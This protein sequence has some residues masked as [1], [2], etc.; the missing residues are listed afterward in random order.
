[1]SENIKKGHNHS[2]GH[3]DESGCEHGC[4]CCH[5][6][7]E[8]SERAEKIE[9]LSLITGATL[10]ALSFL[11]FFTDSTGNILAI[12]SIL[13]AVFPVLRECAQE[14]KNRTI[15][16]NML[17]AIAVFSACVLGDFAEAAAVTVLFRAG[18]ALEEYA[19]NRSKRSITELSQIRPDTA[20]I[21]G[22]D[23]K[24]VEAPAESIKIGDIITVM[25]YER[26]PLDGV[27]TEG[28]SS[29]DASAI[30]GES[31]PVEK[32]EGDGVMS[33]MIN[34]ANILKVEVTSEFSQS[35]ASRIIEMVENASKS[36]GQSERMITRFA[37][38]Y[39][40]AVVTCA[41]LLAVVPIL[42]FNGD[43]SEYI[44]RALVFLVA[45]CPCA[46]V[47]SV[48]LSFF[49]GI[50]AASKKGILVKGGA[51]V[52]T[53]EKIRAVVFDKT[54]TLT[55][56]EF[57]V[58]NVNPCEGVSANELLRIAAAAEFYSSHPIA[59]AIVKAYGEVDEG[60]IKNFKELRAR[61]A[62][63]T[64][65][66]REIL[67]G[68][69]RLMTENGI[70]TNGVQKAEI[71]VAADKKCIGS[72]NVEGK[73][74]D[75]SI[76]AIEDL[77]RLGI[78]HIVI[79]TGDNEA[80][81]KKA[82]RECSIEEYHHSLL[83]EDKIDRLAEIRE[84]YG[85]TAFVGDGINDAP[86]L[87]LADVGVAMGLGTDAAIEAGDVVLMNSAPSKLAAAIRL[88]K[89]TMT[90]T[91]VNIA[92]AVI[93]KIAVLILGAAGIATMW[94]AVFADVGVTILAVLNSSRLLMTKKEQ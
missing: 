92:F 45:S 7:E 6:G 88:F 40:P 16:E 64:L 25:P 66:G 61:G 90:V 11:P 13:A 85:A 10:F 3:N 43:K 62:G 79:L 77:K 59:G 37:R 9:K 65:D 42:F 60:S 58:K 27:I 48:P 19:V 56:D 31:L 4:S 71:Y 41:L 51:Y 69:E 39:T 81:A 38:Y 76:K 35:T 93:I 73:L 67:C 44:H 30:T 72:I 86:S 47:I 78:E 8:K 1:M 63:I 23:G 49:A 29:L 46:L 32:A 83:P 33:G 5:G 55:T 54:G 82:A 34:G 50:G 20:N 80:A 94:A 12:C 74:R 91:R 36:K 17:L 84:K 75:D 21:T 22:Q 70:D 14:V 2:H 18:E 53:L 87:A 57:I 26:V 68:S 89:R 52:E 15:G 28:T 24:I